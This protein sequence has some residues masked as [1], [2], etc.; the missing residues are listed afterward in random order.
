MDENLRA[1]NA[2]VPTFCQ[3]DDHEVINNWSASKDLPRRPLHGE[4]ASLLLGRARG[5][6]FHEMT[7]I[8]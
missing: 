3:W 1:F 6:A 8:R 4:V 7:P 2:E 5:R